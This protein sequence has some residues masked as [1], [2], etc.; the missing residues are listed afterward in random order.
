MPGIANNTMADKGKQ[1][2]IKAYARV[3]VVNTRA[4]LA[5]KRAVE[6]T[7]ATDATG[8][9]LP[10]QQGDSSAYFAVAVSPAKK[11]KASPEPASS[12]ASEKQSE[13]EFARKMSELQFVNLDE[14]NLK[15]LRSLSSKSSRWTVF[16]ENLKI[17]RDFAR[18]QGQTLSAAR[19]IAL[20][21][22]L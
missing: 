3:A 18:R 10:L 21:L 4:R 2:S 9:G 19:E 11:G 22:R 15:L 16:E 1:Q 13:T 20:A 7:V 14:Q 12:L 5:G 6:Q 17:L 8:S